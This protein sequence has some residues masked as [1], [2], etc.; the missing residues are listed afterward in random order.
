MLVFMLRFEGCTFNIVPLI[1]RHRAVSQRM[2]VGG[3]W[4]MVNVPLSLMHLTC[5]FSSKETSLSF[6]DSTFVSIKPAILAV[7]ILQFLRALM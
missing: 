6:V 5:F 7:N 1:T 3:Q 4:S 2:K